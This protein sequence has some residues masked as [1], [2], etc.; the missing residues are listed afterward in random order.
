MPPRAR[1]GPKPDDGTCGVC[2]TPNVLTS[3]CSTTGTAYCR[4]IYDCEL[5]AGVNVK[6]TGTGA[7]RKD[8]SRAWTACGDRKAPD[9][10][11]RPVAVPSEP[12]ED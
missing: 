4:G 10:S 11:E 1:K 5:R 6:G 12:Y 9:G 3:V 7:Q 2:F 8:P